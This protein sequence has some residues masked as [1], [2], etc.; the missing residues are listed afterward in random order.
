M[1]VRSAAWTAAR[2]RRQERRSTPRPRTA[3]VAA[4]VA[5]D[6]LDRLNYLAHLMRRSYQRPWPPAPPLHVIARERARNQQP[7]HAPA[8]AAA[9]TPST[10]TFTQAGTANTNG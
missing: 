4:D 6:E 8:T 9:T 1:T 7:H 10:A 5:A 3:D 2:E